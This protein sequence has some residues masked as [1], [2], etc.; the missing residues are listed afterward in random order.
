MN[1]RKYLLATLIAM[2]VAASA[3]PQP[4]AAQGYNPRTNYPNPS[5]QETQ[6]ARGLACRDPWVS[7]ALQKVKGG[8]NPAFC[9]VTL[10][11][12]G[13]WDSFNT[14]IHAVAGTTGS[15]AQQGADLAPARFPNGEPAVLLK[16][17]GQIVAAGGGNLIGQDGA[18]LIGKG[19]AGV[20]TVPANFIGAGVGSLKFAGANVRYQASKGAV[21]LPKGALYY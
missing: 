9:L 5:Q 13:Q 17:N 11:N 12:G 18:S 10:Y 7:L 21:R 2:A 15:L 4:A 3:L 14:L 8:V 1:A 20:T 19:G 16:L 6:A